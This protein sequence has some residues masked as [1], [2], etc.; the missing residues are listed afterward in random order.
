[1]AA[2]RN[3]WQTVFQ[4]LSKTLGGWNNGTY[5][6]NVKQNTAPNSYTYD[7]DIIFKTKSK[8]EF[9][10][11]SLELKQNKYLRNQWVKSSAKG[12]VRDQQNMA[13]IDL[14]YR[15]CELMSLRPEIYQALNIVSN[16]SCTIGDNGALLNIYSKSE[17]IKTILEDLFVNR[18]QVHMEL[19]PLIRSMLKYGNEYRLLNIDKG[20]GILGWKQLPVAEMKRFETLFPYGSVG[21]IALNSK[22][23]EKMKPHFEWHGGG[24]QPQSFHNWQIAHFRLLN[25]TLYLPFGAS[26]LAGARQQWRRLTM[27]EDAM[28][29][30]ILEKAYDRYVYKIDVGLIDNEDVPAFID[31]IASKIKRTINV[32]PQTGQLDLS[33]NVLPVW[34]NTPIPLLDGRTI[35]IEELSKEYESGK[36]NFVYSIKDKTNEIVPGKVT[37]CGKNYTVEK[38]YKIWLDDNTYMS[39]A[40][41]HPIIMRNGEKKRADEVCAGD[42][43]MGFYI[44][45]EC[46]I[47]QV[48]SKIEIIEGDDVYCM[49]VYGLNGENDRHNFALLTLNEN[50]EPNTSGCFVKNTAVDDLFI[51]VRG[52]KDGTKIDTLSGA[53]NMDKL[54]DNLEYLH[55]QFLTALGVPKIFLNYE[56]SPAEGRNLSLSDVR[57][58]KQVN[59]VQQC[60][61]M[62]LNKIAIIHLYL[63]G[64]TDDLNNF[65]ITMNN[66]ST[67]AEIMRIEELSKKI[68]AV[69]DAVSNAT[70]SGLPIY[71]WRKALKDI[72]KFSDQEIE[73]ILNDIRL[74]K[75]IAT[76]LSL[77]QQIIKRSGVFDKVDLIYGDQNAQYNYDVTEMG[78]AEAAAG[79]GGGG[80]GGDMG[81]D[82]MGGE[83]GGMEGGDIGGEGAEADAG[84]ETEGAPMESRRNKKPVINENIPNKLTQTVPTIDGAKSINEEY[85]LMLGKI[86]E[87]LNH[88]KEDLS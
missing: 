14:M 48:I 33:K 62:E 66:P 50:N 41:E 84:G 79:G 23:E 55:M 46:T 10:Q 44:K 88:N 40:A 78:Q 30:Y 42:S 35:T 85:N 73:E 74:E 28:L 63:L 39:M 58:A 9:D 70:D 26:W 76:E 20:N 13:L 19:L 83:G 4:G 65:T 17:R 21:N 61:I 82:D 11:R 12:I 3:A 52:S 57:F 53:S 22:E 68:L 18:L 54:K 72:M 5:T 71:S 8:E 27:A 75:S 16:E 38:L 47:E 69:K 80:G 34:K 25:D 31:E 37:W 77:T 87:Y 24:G 6:T 81:M 2:S 60:A 51:P 49:S 36:E 32:D 86:D 43:V 1:M 15:D 64:F 45:K 67:Q 29:I 59:R 56:A 7:S